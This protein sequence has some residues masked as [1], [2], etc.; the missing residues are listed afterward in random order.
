MVGFVLPCDELSLPL[1]DSFLAISFKQMEQCFE[2]SSIAKNCFVYMAQPL[3]TNVPAY[4]L[5]CFGISNKHDYTLVIKRRS[6]IVLS[7]CGLTVMSF[8][9]DGDSRKLK[10]M[11]HS[12]HLCHIEAIPSA[13]KINELQVPKEWLSWFAIRNLY[14]IAYVQDT[15]HIAVK[16]KA[17]LLNQSVDLVFGKY[18]AGFH[19]LNTVIESF[20]KDEHG[21]RLKDVNH[22]DRQNYDAVIHITSNSVKD[23]LS[24]ISDAKSTLIYLQFTRCVIDSYLDKNLDVTARIRRLGMQFY[25]MVL[26]TMAFNVPTIYIRGQFYFVK[27][28][29]VY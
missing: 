28:I 16:L 20:G 3:A 6:H 27:C 23:I 7:E 18:I 22:K 21:M 13:L 2:D 8:G 10:A 25:R 15:V 26:A 17:R 29:Q 11:L 12:A 1:A 9:A 4:C 19:H 5:A 14:G 24:T